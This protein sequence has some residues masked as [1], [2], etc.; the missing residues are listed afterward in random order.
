VTFGIQGIGTELHVSLELLREHAGVKVSAIPYTG[1]SQAIIDLVAERLDAMFLVPAAITQH[2]KD[3]RLRA[4]ATIEP[5]RVPA[6]PEV[7][8]MTEIG[9]PQVAGT[10]WFGFTAPSTTPKPIIDKL[11]AAFTKTQQDATLVKKLS[12]L[13]YALR[14]VG[15]AEAGALFAKEREQY[16]KVAAGGRLDKPN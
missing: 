13:G 9:L 8:T 16:G 15:P 7:P 10:P 12:D 5:K 3:G 2:L 11:A 14:V 1:G 6:Y 4:L